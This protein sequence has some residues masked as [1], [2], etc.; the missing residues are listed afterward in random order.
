MPDDP[1]PSAAEI[2]AA[3]T[4][5]VINEVLQL[6][7]G[8]GS[9]ISGKL[10]QQIVAELIDSRATI[11][12]LTARAEAAEQQLAMLLKVS[13]DHVGDYIRAWQRA[14]AL[15]ARV[16]K[17]EA[18]LTELVPIMQRQLDN[19]LA[20]SGP[21]AEAVFNSVAYKTALARMDRARAALAPKEPS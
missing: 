17:L 18:A 6:V 5:A 8:F 9:H 12:T 14:E 4:D 15:A 1:K 2:E 7:V 19:L 3:P 20:Q 11:A 16:A 13:I 10:A 21:Q